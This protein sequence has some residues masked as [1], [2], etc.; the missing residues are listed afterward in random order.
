MIS[1]CTKAEKSLYRM[2]TYCRVHSVDGIAMFKVQ[3]WRFSC[4]LMTTQHNGKLWLLN[5]HEKLKQLMLCGAFCP[6]GILCGGIMSWIRWKRSH[7]CLNHAVR[8]S[9][10]MFRLSGVRMCQAW[11]ATS[12]PISGV[13]ADSISDP[14]M[15]RALSLT[16][17]R[18][19]GY[20][21]PRTRSALAA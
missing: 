13:C 11:I 14:N 17:G 8:A 5:L 19:A 12:S 10:S 4:L 16:T 6:G 15:W 21:Q 3:H 9:T 1:Y 20:K 7:R 18:Q 2:C